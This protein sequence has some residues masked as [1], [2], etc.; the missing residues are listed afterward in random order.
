MKKV[1]SFSSA[2]PF[3]PKGEKKFRCG[4]TKK[5]EVNPNEKKNLRFQRYE[6]CFFV[7][8]R[9]G[10]THRLDFLLKICYYIKNKTYRIS[11]RGTI[12]A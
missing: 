10:M 2:T 6:L 1:L 8:S 11:I 12:N 3:L 9:K 7:I 5:T 4:A